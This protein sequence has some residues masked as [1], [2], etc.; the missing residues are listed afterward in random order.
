[1]LLSAYAMS[2]TD[3]WYGAADSVCCY[4][5]ARRCPVL[6][7]RMLLPGKSRRRKCERYRPTRLLRDVRY[8][9]S[10]CCYAMS[11]TD[12]AYAATRCPVLRYAM[13]LKVRYRDR[14]CCYQS[15]TRCP[16]L[17]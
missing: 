4:A 11:G 13:P 15:A 1:M 5:R 17:R 10:V 12:I 14:L 8:R 16:V 9:H 6:R 7:Q 3:I 2:G